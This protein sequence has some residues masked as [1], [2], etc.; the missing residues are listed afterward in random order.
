MK[1]T[2]FAAM[3][4]SIAGFSFAAEYQCKVNCV[5]SGATYVTVNA[6]SSSDAAQKV[7]KQ[8][9]QICQA[10][11]YTRSTSSTMSAGQCSSK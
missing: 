10:A 1:K 6:S 9:D 3:L 4:M 11:G 2:M 5:P 7:D 8:S